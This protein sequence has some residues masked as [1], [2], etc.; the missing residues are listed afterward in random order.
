MVARSGH[1]TTGTTGITGAR[2]TDRAV[3]Q[4]HSGAYRRALQAPG[5]ELD[6]WPTGLPPRLG[7]RYEVAG[8]LM[9]G[10]GLGTLGI[11]AVR[12]VRKLG[13]QP[14]V[15][16][17]IVVLIPALVLALSPAWRERA[18]VAARGAGWMAVQRAADA[19]DGVDLD[20]LV[21]RAKAIGGGRIYAG[22]RSNW[23]A[24]F[25]IGFVPV[26]AWLADKDAD[27][28]GF[29]RPGG[30]LSAPV[31]GQFDEKRAAQ[32]GL[33]NIRYLILPSSRDPEVPARVI[34][35]RGGYVLWGVNTTGYLEV[36]D[37]VG[38]AIRAGRTN[39]AHQTSWFLR[40]RLL[41]EGRYPTVAFA[42]ARAAPPT[43]V[44]GAAPSGHA[45]TVVKE[46]DRL[47]D[48]TVR[49]DVV[50]SRRSVVLLK[51]T[52]DPRWK[53]YVDGVIERPQFVA[54]S[55]VGTQVGPGAH[56]V[57]FTYVPYPGYWWLTGIGVITLLA[58][59]KQ[60]R[61]RETP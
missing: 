5:R 51:A 14:D 8:I 56:S 1:W 20:A 54:P 39:M 11:L 21:R 2:G 40:S 27:Q 16:V 37:S 12:L 9:A 10:I 48:G 29:V 4:W 46:L 28:I 38:P 47:A 6:L 58:L 50:A 26:Y 49:A 52:F 17:A 60:G 32:Y 43:L 30:S 36:V 42:G 55:F 44:E 33:F 35:W 24:S 34:A 57:V 23:G 59:R 61:R 22:S 7:K 18:R 19:T 45:G 3:F 31:E 13:P 15:A 53:V 41:E 25:R